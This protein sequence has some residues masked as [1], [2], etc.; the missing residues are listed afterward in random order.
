MEWPRLVGSLTLYTGDRELAEDLA[1]E[2]L[3]RA[4]GH[5]NEVC[6]L[7]TPSAWT[8]RVAF[9]LAKSQFRRML[10]RRRYQHI[11]RLE[12]V[13]H[14]P[15]T[16]TRLAVRKAVEGLPEP[17]RRALVLRYF[18]DLS[19]REVAALM[20]CPNNTVKTHTRRAIEALRDAGL[21]ADEPEPGFLA[22]GG[23]T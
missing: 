10:V 1:Q 13:A 16:P 22:T 7:A 20:G 15:D 5:W 6:A 3:I 8:H 19:V 18:A 23:T 4:C 11:E 14:D 12:L 17:Q 2:T 9:N 21:V